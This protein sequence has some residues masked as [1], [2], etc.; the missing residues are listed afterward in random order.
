MLTT[1][2]LLEQDLFYTIVSLSSKSMWCDWFQI[3]RTDRPHKIIIWAYLQVSHSTSRACTGSGNQIILGVWPFFLYLYF[4]NHS[5]DN[6]QQRIRARFPYLIPCFK[7]MIC[8]RSIIFGFFFCFN[9]E[10]WIDYLVPSKI[11]EFLGCVFSFLSL[12]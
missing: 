12:K 2:L 7:E 5:S 1:L 10:L 9:V 4:L 11:V 3:W 8:K 6:R